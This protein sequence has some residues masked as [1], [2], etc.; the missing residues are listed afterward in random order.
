MSILTRRAFMKAAAL[1]MA[2]LSAGTLWGCAS[3]DAGTQQTQGEAEGVLPPDP[4]EELI[5]GLSLEQKISQLFVVRPEDML[6]VYRAEAQA[7]D[8]EVETEG[9]ERTSGG[10]GVS[11]SDDA[12]AVFQPV[13]ELTEDMRQAIA[14]MPVGGFAFFAKNLEDPN[15]TEGFL[16]QLREC[17]SAVNGVEPLL[18]VDE[19]GGRVARI[20]NNDSFGVVNVGDVADIGAGDNPDLA[21]QAAEE[22]ARYLKPLGF[23]TDFAPV[24][25]IADNP[26]N[27][28]MARRSFGADADEVARMV[29][30]TVTGFQEEGMACC[31]KH[32]PG[33][34]S[35]EGDSH[36]GRISIQDDLD[37]LESSELKPFRAGIEA[38]APLVMMSHLSVPQVTGD[39][40]PACLSEV[41]VNDVLRKQLGFKGVVITD[42]LGMRAVTDY[43]SPGDAAVEAIKAGCDIVLMPANLQAAFDALLAAVTGGFISEER[44]DESLRRVLSLKEHY[45]I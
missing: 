24:C 26:E 5:A 30:A 36:T 11:G 25:D 43:H 10:A 8:E 38:G 17:I 2:S 31:L 29:A 22:I 6:G 9:G 23:N 40:T 34:G 44:I 27:D 13:T 32:F 18:C 42:S 39:D 16:A 33:L 7:E 35:A 12:P 37:G 4:L 15:Q 45:L 21:K 3:D 14:T 28:T 19:E 1:G 20:A 41:M